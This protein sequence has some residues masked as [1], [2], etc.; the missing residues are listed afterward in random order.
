M[1][2]VH[3]IIIPLN[4]CLVTVAAASPPDGK[5]IITSSPWHLYIWG[6]ALLDER[7]CLGLRSPC[8]R[9]LPLPF[10]L[11]DALADEEVKAL[12]KGSS[13]P[14]VSLIGD[15]LCSHGSRLSTV[16]HNLHS[17]RAQHS[18]SC[19]MRG[20]SRRKVWRAS[21]A[22]RRRRRSHRKMTRAAAVCHA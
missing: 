10:S 22:K 18:C 21:R 16:L 7:K 8:S 15:G 11:G 3:H 17:A 13:F 6:F 20:C 9:S 4:M 12:A 14:L 2:M 1:N 19:C 5:C